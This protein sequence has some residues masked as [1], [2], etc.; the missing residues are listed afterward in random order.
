MQENVRSL[1][2]RFM[3]LEAH[4]RVELTELQAGF[5]RIQSQLAEGKKRKR[6][7]SQEGTSFYQKRVRQ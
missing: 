6:T 7:A 5:L 3:D 1:S 4:L 2:Q